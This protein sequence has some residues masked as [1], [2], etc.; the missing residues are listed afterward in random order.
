MKKLTKEELID[1]IREK[2][3]KVTKENVDIMSQRIS[4]SLKDVTNFSTALVN[5]MAAYGS[6][7]EKECCYIFAET[8]YEILYSE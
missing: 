6:E 5:A 8:L 1:L 3:R 2:S 7:L 4:D